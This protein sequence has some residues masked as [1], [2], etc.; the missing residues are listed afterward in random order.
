MVNG[1][2]NYSN[3][4]LTP[5][6]Y[7]TGK[8]LIKVTENDFDWIATE[9]SGEYLF[10]LSDSFKTIYSNYNTSSLLLYIEIDESYL[11]SCNIKF[12]G[13]EAET[14][15]EFKVYKANIKTVT[16]ELREVAYA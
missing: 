11:N 14:F 10:K 2:A 15:G 7:F 5:S 9:N 16:G 1:N 3:G 6:D 12:A 13:F 8:T 4:E